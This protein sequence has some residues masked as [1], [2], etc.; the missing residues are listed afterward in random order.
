M[1]LNKI[2]RKV[3]AAAVVG[4]MAVTSVGLTGDMLPFGNGLVMD[5]GAIANGSSGYCGKLPNDDYVL[6]HLIDD[7]YRTKIKYEFCDGTLALSGTGEME[8]YERDIL[9]TLDH[10]ENVSLEW[11]KS[12]FEYSDEIEKIVIGEGITS[13][14]DYNFRGCTN[15][16]EVIIP[17]TVTSIGQYAFDGC[18]GLESITIPG[19][20]TIDYTAFNNCKAMEN[21]IIANGTTEIMEGT[22]QCWTNI[23]NVKLPYS[24][25]SIGDNAFRECVGLTN[26]TIPDSVTSIG[27]AAFEECTSLTSIT[28]PESVTTISRNLFSCCTELSS[29]TLHDGITAI[30]DYAFVYC[31]NLT[32]VTLPKK[33]EKIG[34][35]AFGYTGLTSVTIPDSVVS[36]SGFYYCTE[37]KSI[38]IPNG[39]KYINDKAFKGCSGLT[40]VTIPNTVNAIYKEAFFDCTGL[41]SITI[42]ESVTSIGE[43]AFS[44]CTG[45]TD[46]VILGDLTGM[47]TYA[48]M[49]CTNLTSLTIDDG[50]TLIGAGAFKGCT[51]LANVTI[52]D[53]VTSIGGSAFYGCTNLKSI[54]IPDSV[55]SIGGSAFKGCTQLTSVTIPKDVTL[56]YGST[57]EGCRGLTSITIPENVTIIYEK[58]FY[59]C[60]GIKN[61]IIPD[62]VKAIG[63]RAFANCTSLTNIVI[64]DSVVKYNAIS[65]DA[66]FE[67]CA[68]LTIFCNSGSYAETIAKQYNIDYCIIGTLEIAEQPVDYTGKIGDTAYFDVIVESSKLTYQWEQNAG[69]GWVAIDSVEAKTANFSLVID[70]E[71]SGYSYR[72]VVS[73]FTDS[74]TSDE[75]KIIVEKEELAI[76]TQ[77]TDYTGKVDETATFTIEATGEDI[78]Y[79][80]Q[81]NTGS[82]WTDISEATS[83]SY[84]VVLDKSM[85]GYKYRCV[86]SDGTDSITSDEAQLTVKEKLVITTQPNN[87]TGEVGETTTFTIEAT[88]EDITYQWQQ[89]TGSSW[90]DVSGVT[91]ASYSVVLV[92]SMNGYKYRCVVS[93]GIDSITSD[94]VQ[95]TV[96][97]K[98]AITT[99]PVDYTGKD[100]E[101]ATFTVAATGDNLT[102]Q[103]QQDTGAGWTNINTTA[104]RKSSFSLAITVARAKYQYRCVVSDG[105][106]DIISDAVKM[107]ITEELAITT[108]PIDYTGKV[109]ETA[110]FTVAA[111]GEEVTYQWQQ[112][113]GSSWTDISG[114]TIAT[115]SVVLDKDMNGYK[116]RCVVSDGTD[117]ITSDEVQ[118]IVEEDSSDEEAEIILSGNC[119]DDVTYTLDSNGLLTIF[120]EGDM[121][122]YSSY[123]D[124]PWYSH[125]VKSVII[126]DCVTSVGE[127]AFGECTELTS[128][129]LPDGMTNIN[130][131]AFYNCS[132]ITNMILPESITEIGV[133]AFCGC[134]SLTSIVIPDG[135]TVITASV[136]YQCTGLTDITIPDSVTGI[137]SKAFYECTSLKKIKFSENMGFIND[138]AFDN[139]TNLTIYCYKGSYTETFAKEHNIPYVIVPKL[140]ITTQPTDYTGKVGETATFTVKATGENLT[141]QWQQNTGSSWSDISGA[142]SASYSVV[143]DEAIDGYMYRC[144]VS[145][146]KAS[147]ISNE[148]KIT[149][150]KSISGKCGDNV[151]YKYNDCKLVISGTG[152]IMDY[153]SDS[154]PFCD[155]DIKTVIIENGITSIGAYAFSN[156]TSLESIDLPDSITSINEGAFSNC[157][158]L[159]SFVIPEKVKIINDYVFSE[160]S[161]L[162]S[163]KIPEGVTSI[164]SNAFSFCVSLADVTI[165]ENV[166]SIGSSA[167]RDCFRITS[168]TIPDGVTSI[169]ERVFAG[170]SSVESITIPNGVTSIGSSAFHRCTS[171]SVIVIPDSVETIGSVAFYNCTNLT[172]HCNEGSYAKRYAVINGMPYYIIGSVLITSQPTD[173]TG[174][175]G[176]TA[177]FTVEATGENLTY[178]WQQNTGTS[179]TNIDTTAGRKAAFSIGVTSLRSNYYYRCKITDGKYTVYSNE[180][181][182]V[183]DEEFA[184]TTQPTD[185]T[186]AIGDTAKFTVEATGATSYQWYQNTGAGWTA[187]NTTV[188]RSKTFSVAIAQFRLGYK[189][190]CVVSD[191]TTE[192]TSDEVQMVVKGDLTITTQPSNY[193]GVIGDTAKFTVEATGATSYQW[194]QNTGAGWTAINTTAGRSNTFSIAIAEFRLGYLYR[195]VVSD[196]TNTIT[197]DEVQMYIG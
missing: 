142:T 68:N 141:Y 150:D 181:K 99:Q 103:W 160:C 195:C 188:G 30:E 157:T 105:T 54:T 100:G 131:C 28:I 81:Q 66:P 94:E 191:G 92:K 51:Q 32:D 122:D 121:E 165:P 124:Q 153:E 104:G 159:T 143:I 137:G 187:I 16:K 53:S 24:L 88:G 116:Y 107:I 41:T 135:V 155:L 56:I 139:C 91:S 64:P 120:G 52:S 82:R 192:I 164:G 76:I 39:V 13:I 196:G 34:T 161:K 148:V 48:F 89:N 8:N 63:E 108:Q 2:L 140:A 3:C 18:T 152:A 117:S 167:F 60:T 15:L 127:Y 190:R 10:G 5:V 178:Q 101:T 12:P 80:W 144:V 74:V 11:I 180:V 42:P 65:N 98:L 126:E 62:G 112:N 136:F 90:T 95:L 174:K 27:A 70:K 110:T 38:T 149:I 151:N 29:V 69:D 84:S 169:E 114:A 186:G 158:S 172:I 106:T 86:V 77:P 35:N 93:D 78:T 118:V 115:Y 85:N 97:E 79:Q 133:A 40:N 96:K 168:I 9:R 197:S 36:L 130:Y 44:G 193:I 7:P 23:K 163:V 25:T 138:T 176:D 45:L 37:L 4:V 71:N 125:T 31:E 1:K 75:V 145:D 72:C 194:Y 146:E 175:V 171:L 22:F 50:V 185:Y 111:T 173:Y 19:T 43:K 189:Y 182:M 154:S 67:N 33:L 162:T 128:V 177:I 113:T 129:T 47:G 183:I 58:A 184:I 14:G 26:I 61:I 83:A 46:V 109:G 55:T 156:C 170:C 57:F 49:D 21:L 73:N 179:W 147:I 123:T 20:V 17:I 6:D 132:G 102:Y 119:G 166:T 87:Y 59:G 134:T